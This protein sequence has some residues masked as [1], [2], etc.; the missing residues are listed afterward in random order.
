MADEINSCLTQLQSDL[1]TALV[2]ATADKVYGF[3]VLPDKLA[4]SVRPTWAGCPERGRLAA[5]A[6]ITISRPF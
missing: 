1:E 2:S 3:R 5:P 6:L 4:K